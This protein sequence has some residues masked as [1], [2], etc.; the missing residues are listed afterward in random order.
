M[1]NCRAQEYAERRALRGELKALQKEER[2][3]QQR[4]VDEVLKVGLQAVYTGY[5]L[6]LLIAASWRCSSEGLECLCCVRLC[7]VLRAW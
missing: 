5:V 1:E 3:R 2:V 7:P 4:A 6:M